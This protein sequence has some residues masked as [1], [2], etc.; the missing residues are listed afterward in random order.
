MSACEA[1]CRSILP[2]GEALWQ[3]PGLWL[4]AQEGR[5][6]KS[7]SLRF[8]KTYDVVGVLEVSC[9]AGSL[10]ELMVVR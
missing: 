3:L 7:P 10:A 5:H 8:G 2:L 9:A 6:R 4:V 1:S